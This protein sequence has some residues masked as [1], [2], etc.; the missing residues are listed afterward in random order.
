MLQIHRQI[1]GFALL[2]IVVQYTCLGN[3]HVIAAYSFVQN[4]ESRTADIPEAHEIIATIERAYALLDTPVEL[5][6]FDE[7]DAV[8][9][10][11]PDYLKEISAQRR[12]ALH[13][14]ITEQLGAEAAQTFGYRT[15][16]KSKRIA[17]K[18]RIIQVRS[19]MER[20]K[21]ENRELTQ[22]ELDEIA[23]QNQGTIPALSD[24]SAPPFVR[25]LEYFSLKIDGDT[26]RAV[27]DEG[28]T[29]LT[30][31]L[32]RIDGKWYVAGIF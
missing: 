9:I 15:S 32:K 16:M 11:H 28:V 23:K 22:A 20:A 6:D 7:F 26:A 29:G 13:E 21:A 24:L 17:D 3:Q 5:L 25:K 30:A 8:F 10:D 19:A 18:N 1:I 14:Q 31:I 12:T 27:Y 4:R 2:F